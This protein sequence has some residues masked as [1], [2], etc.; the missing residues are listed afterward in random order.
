MEASIFTAE[1]EV[2]V[3]VV[4]M[5]QKKKLKGDKGDWKEFLKVHDKKM[6]DSVSDPAK[7]SIDDLVI[8]I[9]T[10]SDE[11]DIKFLAKMAHTVSNRKSGAQLSMSSTET[12]S[13]QERLVRATVQHPDYLLNYSFYPQNEDWVVIKP[14]KSSKETKSTSIVAVDCE[15]VL[16]ED[17]SEA[18]VQVCV[19]DQN[20]EVKLN[21]LVHPN[22]AV[23]NYRTEI[24]GIS[25]KDVEG[26]TC[27]L[28]DIQRKM[29]KLL[30]HGIILVGHSLNNDLQA[31]KLDHARVV[32][33]SYIFATPACRKP[34]LN[35]LC[36]NV[37]G[38]EVRKDGSPHNCLD[39]ARAAMK[40]VLFKLES[41]I[42]SG[43]AGSE[44]DVPESES[45]KLLLHR[46]PK[47]V[48]Q[49]ELLKIFPGFTVELQR[50]MNVRKPQQNYAVVA[51]FKNPNEANEA[52]DSI[53]R[54]EQKDCNGLRQKLVL[55]EY[56]AER[57]ATVYVRKMMPD[58]PHD[59]STGSKK[60]SADVDNKSDIKKPKIDSSQC[61]HHVI[62]IERLKAE[63]RQKDDEI[64]SMQKI[65]AALTRKQ[66]L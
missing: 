35:D 14:S 63:L 4:K 5:A 45:A 43:V 12:E 28:V 62:E 42:D 49:G 24:T 37:L 66:G 30:R 48:P 33:T 32:D 61:D 21:E 50:R 31:L 38:Y 20:M 54:E 59:Q 3:A 51:V 55:F 64:A 52:F 13:P 17:G 60:R 23:A 18:V 47:S 22:K 44:K 46:I 29:K 2:L 40:L 8:F 11:E 10:F 9:K 6:G 26:V 7:R 36:K 65:I 57:P 25:A 53:E 27:S 41:G 1:K 19:V 16:C 15:M 34:S 56:S 39:D 58:D